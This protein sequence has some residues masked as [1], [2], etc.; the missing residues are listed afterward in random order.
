VGASKAC[1]PSQE[2]YE[3]YKLKDLKDH[4]RRGCPMCLEI[5]DAL[6]GKEI[7]DEPGNLGW[8]SFYA[9]DAERNRIVCSC[10]NIRT[11]VPAEVKRMRYLKAEGPK[12]NDF[13]MSMICSAEGEKSNS[14]V[15]RKATFKDT[16]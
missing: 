13:L 10:S 3:H 9:L 16:A 4:P 14:S 8:I 15:D 5:L 12:K 6:E 2:G 1:K 7:E 11:E